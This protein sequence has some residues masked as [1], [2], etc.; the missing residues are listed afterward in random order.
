ML[1]LITLVL[2]YSLTSISHAADI[3]SKVQKFDWDGLEVVWVEDE[4]FPTYDVSVYFADGALSDEL[5][6]DTSAA[7]GL[8][9]LGTTRYSQKDLID[10]LEFFGVSSGP[11]VTHEYSLYSVSGLVKDS[12]PTFKRICHMFADATYP[13]KELTREI[14]RSRDATL[15]LVSDKSTIASMAFRELSLAGSPYAYPVSAK[16]QDLLKLNN[17][18]HLKKRLAYFNNEVYKRVYISG[19]KEIL[20]IKEILNQECGW[21]GKTAT[22]KRDQ[23]FEK[24]D[25]QSQPKIYLVTVPGSNQAQVRIGK[26]MSEEEI[27]PLET[28]E[29]L[30]TYLGGGF[31]SL[32]M[33]ELRSSRGLVYGAGAFAAGQKHYGRGV[34][35]TSTKNESV[36]ELLTVVKGLLDDLK[37]GKVRQDIFDVSKGRLEGSYPFRFE[38]SSDFLQQLIYLDHIDTKY[39]R[40]LNFPDEL[41]KVSSE[42]MAKWGGR[43][44]DWN[45]LTIVVQGDKSLE[46]ELSEFGK[47]IIKN[48]KEFL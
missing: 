41:K 5:K 28:I 20:K 12:I 2:I 38:K 17:P 24:S 8:L 16:Y 43:I 30:S 9:S 47:V 44:F 37:A 15:N 39:S 1:K 35:Q 48:Y 45:K 26:L 14:K 10:H 32:L 11:Y 29:L 22:F 42:D 21:N 18:K 13:K 6:G 7:L 46:K 36:K 33:R 31:T 40:F 34:I 3:S 4:R 23:K 27:Q 19:P 25:D